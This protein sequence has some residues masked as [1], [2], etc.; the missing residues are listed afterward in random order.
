MGNDDS[1]ILKKVGLTASQ[2]RE[3]TGNKGTP[4]AAKKYLSADDQKRMRKRLKVYEGFIF[5]RYEEGYHPDTIAKLIGVSGESVKRRLRAAGFF[6][7][8]KPRHRKR[9]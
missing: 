1:H 4:P 7:K 2:V 3:M 8:E 5:A 6:K 9:I